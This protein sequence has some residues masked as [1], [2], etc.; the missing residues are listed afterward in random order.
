[1][2]VIYIT[3]YF[4][5]G[6]AEVWA[7]NELNSLKIHGKD[8]LIIPKL[9]GYSIINRDAIPFESNVIVF[10]F[11]NYTILKSLFQW[12][13][14]R[15]RDLFGIFQ[16]VL[17]LS[18]NISDFIKGFVILPKTLKLIDVLKDKNIEHIHSFSLN[19]N[20]LMASII[21]KHIGVNWS[22]TLH[23][24]EILN[25]NYKRSIF[26]LSQ[27]ASLCRTIS[28]RTADDLSNFLGFNFKAKIKTVHLGVDLDIN[29]DEK[30]PNTNS[31]NIVTASELT[32][33]K[34]HIY[35]LKASKYLIEN[36]F[37]QFQW[38][39]YGS[40]PLENRI[41]QQIKDLNLTR[42]CFLKGNIDHK[43]LLEKYKS[44]SVHL[45]ILP[46]IS[47]SVPEGIPVSLME[48][49]SYK[50]PVIATDC[51]ATSELVDG[52][53]G[54]LVKETDYISIAKSIIE[55]SS[56]N[57]YYAKIGNAGYDNIIRNFYTINNA[58]QLIEYFDI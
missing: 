14:F 5:Y 26:G 12:C 15:P 42:H 48:A 35:A 2:A 6:K 25:V 45:V 23:T 54:I 40:G 32:S 22:Y 30:I 18:N 37:T 4:P 57:T 34:G 43:V 51:G 38:N 31:I 29:T 9:S 3:S 7:I 50:I 39:F 11:V 10:P 19:T 55:L 33:R 41:R 49:M 16:K 52:S 44:G 21:A 27:S 8:V 20:A 28:K 56:N 1:M 13:I 47:T 58:K 53:T 46:S 24:S 36:G 17:R